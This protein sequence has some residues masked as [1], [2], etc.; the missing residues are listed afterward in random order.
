MKLEQIHMCTECRAS[1]HKL[2]KNAKNAILENEGNKP[3]DL[4]PKNMG[5]LEDYVYKNTIKKPEHIGNIARI[6]VEIKKTWN[7]GRR[8]TVSFMGGTTIMR[9]RI[10]RHAMDW[11]KYANIEFDFNPPKNTVADIRIAFDKNGGSWSYLG[12]EI[13]TID[14]KLP[15]MNFGWLTDATDDE[16]YHR[17]VLHEFGH[18]LGCIHEHSSPLGGVPWDKPKA[19]QYYQQ[20]GWTKAEVDEQV[21]K[22]YNKDLI[23]GTAVD[24]K[25]I[26]MY[27][28][29]EDITIGQFS[30]GWNN[31]LSAADKKFI[32]SMYPKK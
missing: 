28:I 12:T 27:P 11:S 3:R 4:S 29:P 30:V 13:L 25:S 26:M 19:Y 22:R 8:L 2:I 31:D 17:V 14:K 15:T 32:A 21:F 20:Q 1:H 16:E 6:A 7:P 24:K 5:I 18:T 23:R 9:E 10:Q